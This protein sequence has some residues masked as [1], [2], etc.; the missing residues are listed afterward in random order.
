M[1]A[2]FASGHAD[3]SGT[4][5]GKAKKAADG[6]DVPLVG[7]LMIICNG[8]VPVDGLLET[9]SSVVASTRIGALKL[10]SQPQLSEALSHVTMA[11]PNEKNQKQT[12]NNVWFLIWSGF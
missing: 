2:C 9:H 7:L 3:D 6:R 1:C 8:F 11:L 5:V 10:G 4:E 12:S